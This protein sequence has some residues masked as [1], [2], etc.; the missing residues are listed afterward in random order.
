MST[1]TTTNNTQLEFKKAKL[2]FKLGYYENRTTGIREDRFISKFD[3]KIVYAD[4]KFNIKTGVSYDCDIKLSHQR[5]AYEVSHHPIKTPVIKTNLMFELGDKRYNEKTNDYSQ[6][7]VS[8]FEG[9]TVI[10]DTRK[11]NIEPQKLY[12]CEVALSPQGKAYIVEFIEL[13]RPAEAQIM[14][15]E[16]PLSIVE[17]IIDGTHQDDLRFDCM[18]G[19]EKMLHSKI[20]NFRQKSIADKDMVISNYEATCRD[21]MQ[22][23]LSKIK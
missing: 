11:F 10:A 19:D 23:H 7:W 8:K 9:R 17:V 12:S 21:L 15:H 16:A 3:G 22:K 20:N 2:I 14:A 4:I 1:D 5:R 6:N 18:A 13:T